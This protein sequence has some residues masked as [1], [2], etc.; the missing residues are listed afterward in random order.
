MSG[1]SI[2]K[3]K[4]HIGIWQG[5]LRRIAKSEHFLSYKLFFL[6]HIIAYY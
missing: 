2:D 5:I 4:K 1:S 3:E 6:T